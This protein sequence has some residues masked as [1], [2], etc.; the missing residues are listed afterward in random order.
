MKSYWKPRVKAS[1]VAALV[2]L[3]AIA[4]GQE[5]VENESFKGPKTTVRYSM[6]G[7][8]SEV[9]TA[10]VICREFVRLNPDLRIEVAVYPWGQ[11]WAKVQTQTASGLAPDVLSFASMMFGVWTARGA[12]MPLDD[13]AAAS[14]LD[15]SKFHRPAI[16]NCRWGG[17]LYALPLE[18][19]LW[20]VIYS[21]DRFEESNIPKSEWPKPDVP[22]TW[23]EFNSLARRLTLRNRDGTYRQYGM[24]AGQNWNNCML[25]MDGGRLVDRPIDPTRSTAL[26]PRV[27]SAATQLFEAQYG[28]RTTLGASPLAAG[29]FTASTDVLLLS[30]RFAMGTTGPWTLKELTERGVRWGLTPLPTGKMPYQMIGVNSVGIYSASKHPREAYRFVEFM[31]SPFVQRIIGG[32][33]KGVPALIEAKDSFINNQAGVPGV[34]AYLKTLEYAEPGI[35]SSNSYVLGE[36][37]KWISETDTLLD[38]EYDRRLAALPRK[39]NAIDP[40]A[41]RQFEDEMSAY[42]QATV[43]KQVEK[44]DER[45]RGAFARAQRPPPSP[46]VSRV[47]PMI[48]VAAFA[49]FLALYFVTARKSRAEKDEPEGRMQP[50]GY[51]FIAPW[52]IGFCCFVF[53]PIIASILLSFTEWNMIS[54]PTWVGAQHYVELPQDEKFLIGLKNTFTYAIFAIPISLIGGLFTAGLLTSRVKGANLFKALLYF[55]ALMTGAEAAVLWVNML[56]KDR[57]VINLILGKLGVAPVNWMDQSHAMMSVL[58]MNVFWVGGAMLIYYAAMRQIPA[59]LYEAADL[60]GA[61]AARKFMKITIPMLSPVI[62]FMIVMSTIGAFQVFTP[63]LFFAKSSTSIGEPGDALRFYSVNMYDAAFNNLRMGEACSYAIILFAIIFTIT[64]IQMRFARRFVHTE[65]AP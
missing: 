6:W 20:T 52:L 29:S 65:S 57:G 41:F 1:F 53:G 9:E 55:P 22:M 50:A 35:T 51:L 36:R 40:A 30:N 12:L 19:P 56:D 62:L 31:V 17:K 28:H 4:F 13:L 63:A 8:A 39:G 46:F 24:S 34:E 27:I 60:D 11:Y 59:S 15:V 48:M 64:M 14:K 5:V 38:A 23:D 33:L 37:D 43:K 58:M 44:L 16:E 45:L 21:K 47:L 18:M 54:P 3:A 32:S 49:A 61:S 26:D 10:R 2:A 7:G 25:E 42:V